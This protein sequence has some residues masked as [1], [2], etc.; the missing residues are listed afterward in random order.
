MNNADPDPD[1]DPD[2]VVVALVPGE[3]AKN[4][5]L[6]SSKFGQPGSLGHRK[7]LASWGRLGPS[8]W[9]FFN[10]TWTDRTL[11]ESTGECRH[12]LKPIRQEYMCANAEAWAG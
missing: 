11:F 10:H 6:D 1:P 4:L 5:T 8:C 9:K 3:A 12:R 2:P 7:D